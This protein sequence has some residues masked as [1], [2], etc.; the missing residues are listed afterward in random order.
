MADFLDSEASESDVSKTDDQNAVGY[1]Q[2]ALGF[3]A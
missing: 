2:M 3:D 1:D